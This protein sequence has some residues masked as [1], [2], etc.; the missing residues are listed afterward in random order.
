MLKGFPMKWLIVAVASLTLAVACGGDDPTA[1]PVPPA[2]TPTTAAPAATATPTPT[3]VPGAPTP[4]PR[5]PTPTPKPKPTATPPP[6]F[7]A[8]AHFKGK[9]IRFVSVSPPGGGTDTQARV[10]AARFGQFLPGNPRIVV[11]DIPRVAGY[12]YMHQAKPDGY[13]I[14]YKPSPGLER[15]LEPDAKF[16]IHDFEIV[17]SVGLAPQ[18]WVATKEAPYDTLAEAIAAGPGG[19]PLVMAESV[20]GEKNLLGGPL[21][22]SF[23]C[24]RLQMPCKM[25]RVAEAGTNSQLLM[26]ERGEINSNLRGALWTNLY[27]L[28]P[29]KVADGTFKVLG[30]AG[31]PDLPFI[32]NK[33]KDV[34]VVNAFEYLAEK[35]KADYALVS[36]PS[37]LFI[38]AMGLPPEAP[39]HILNLYRD[40]FARAIADDTFAEAL[41][42]VAGFD[43]RL[44]YLPGEKIQPVL[45]E[46]SIT[47]LENQP[48][49]KELQ[50][51]LFKYWK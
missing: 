6:S 27:A 7:D 38:K 3:L 18:G 11:S 46:T 45:R 4:T 12:N 24:D 50:A 19:A 8:E 22:A 49:I 15:Q 20:A 10:I 9:T 23:L 35:D 16:K 30:I 32:Q 47:Y 39:D 14:M 2:T 31:P 41:S 17:A 43:V 37:T 29:G 34:E 48:R 13:T 40:A 21:T 33:E 42:R 26:M 5:P 44:T 36:Y 51:Q 28:R 25:L 1:T